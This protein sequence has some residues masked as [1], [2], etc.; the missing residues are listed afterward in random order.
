MLARIIH[1]CELLNTALGNDS[2]YRGRIDSAIEKRAMFYIEHYLI[3]PKLF[4]IEHGFFRTPTSIERLLDQ[5]EAL[6]HALMTSSCVG[7]VGPCP[8]RY[9]LQSDP[10]A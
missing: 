1:E 6:P 8:L 10:I 4:A 5:L 9:L 3:T 2:I 7:P